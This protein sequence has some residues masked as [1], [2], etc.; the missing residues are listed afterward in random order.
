MPGSGE[1]ESGK[2]LVKGIFGQRWFRVP[3][4]QRPYVWTSDEV[5]ELLED[6]TFAQAEKPNDEYFL[7]SFVYQS[8]R[9]DQSEGQEF[10]ENDLLDGQQ[11]M[12]KL[13]ML[14]A[15][16]RDLVDCPKAKKSCQECIYQDGDEFKKIPER[17]RL[18]FPIRPE[19]EEFINE[20]IKE[21]DGTKREDDLNRIAK[22]DN[23]VS[24]MAQAV[25]TM[26][27]FFSNK[28]TADIKELLKFLLNK[29][30]LIYVSTD[31]LED[32][33]RLFTILNDRGIPLRN[34]DI[35]K[36]MNL[37]ALGPEEDKGKYAKMW[38]EAENELGENF[39]KFLDHVR[40][41]LVK[42]KA[43]GSLL[44]E[45]GV[46]I[47]GEKNKSIG[48]R[49]PALLKKGKE[50]F[51]LMKKYLEHRRTVFS[52][53]NVKELTNWGFDNLVKVMS[54]EL[55]PDWIPPL[56]RYFDR[57]RFER[58]LE[59]LK[60]LDNKFSADWISESSTKRING[61][62][63]VI[64]VIDEAGGPDEVLR[65]DCFHIDG[66]SFMTNVSDCVVKKKC[67]KYLLLKLDY[68]YQDPLNEI[69]VKNL[70]V[71]HIL[72]Q[73][74]S[75]ESQWVRDFNPDQRTDW[76]D[77]LGNL[78][79]ISRSKNPSLGRFDYE[80]KKRRCFEENITTCPNSLRVLNN[81]ENWT[82]RELEKNHNDVLKKLREHYEIDNP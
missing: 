44:Q 45:Y 30:V 17:S 59:F 13:L 54:E 42:D 50:T 81:N 9:V 69:S 12:T 26:H 38:E 2:I 21:R 11:R 15:V 76:T 70:S 23:N 32:A 67:V 1:I 72:P 63:R 28:G 52:E 41:I 56:L 75:G 49:K 19:V 60:K 37:G 20:Y 77:R 46:K 57:F 82:L 48:E 3:E 78:M 55:P 73:N 47:Y 61:M 33:F 5:T 34:S 68:L 51:E 35:L 79:L 8:K 18:V 31:G 39:E 4:Y 66:C 58:M 25:L 10:D 64:Q 62:N 29:V 53:D 14:F 71:E 65:S 27:K 22:S 24:R 74:P 6:L 80:E 40:T 43:R 36:S 16:I 7:G